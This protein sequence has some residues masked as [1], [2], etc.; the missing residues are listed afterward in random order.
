[1]TTIC[2]KRKQLHLPN[3]NMDMS[4]LDIHQH[5]T[6]TG[7]RMKRSMRHRLLQTPDGIRHYLTSD[8]NKNKY[9]DINLVTTS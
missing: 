7:T 8:D 5:E 9:N 4:L 3:N 6:V 1:M 2:S